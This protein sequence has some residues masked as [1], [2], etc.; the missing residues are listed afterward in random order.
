MKEH[1]C[2]E[3]IV[4]RTSATINNVAKQF[5]ASSITTDYDTVLTS[6]NIDLVLISTRHN[7]HARMAINALKA[8][9]AVFLEKPMAMDTDEL[10]ELMNL[11]QELNTP[12]AFMV[13][14]NRRFSP[15]AVKA[16]KI[17][18]ELKGPVVILYRVK[19]NPT[20]L[21]H[22]VQTAEGGGR[23]IGEACHMIDLFTYLTGSQVISID[24][25]AIDPG[26]TG[27]LV[28]DNFTTTLRYADGSICTLVYT[29]QGSPKI[30]KERIEIF[31]KD[32]SII[33]DDFRKLILPDQPKHNWTSKSA[34][35]GHL[36]EL[37]AFAQT[38]RKGAPLPIPFDEMVS[39][40]L[41]TFQIHQMLTGIAL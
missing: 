1:Y 25:E 18:E 11:Y 8:N 3:A 28:T 32:R 30:S 4:G 24:A 40:T 33:I 35:K 23:V 36:A 19:A 7:L 38:T 22:W 41:I 15:A 39:T 13:G 9:K 34:D 2:L 27:L 31:V 20:P 37:K 16:R 21:D 26:D 14:F 29:S 5:A 17:I 12:P 10:N 6:S